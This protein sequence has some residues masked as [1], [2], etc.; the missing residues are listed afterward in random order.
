MKPVVD[1]KVQV[2]FAE[3]KDVSD[4]KAATIFA[5]VVD[6]LDCNDVPQQNK[7][8]SGAFRFYS[9]QVTSFPKAT[10]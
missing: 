8:E 7:S 1:G 9:C 10:L 4:G 3:N 6:F 5:A 2:M